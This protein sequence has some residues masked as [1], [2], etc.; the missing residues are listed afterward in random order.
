MAVG[1]FHLSV[2][3]VLIQ[4][5]NKEK[6]NNRKNQVTQIQKVRLESRLTAVFPVMLYQGYASCRVVPF[7]SNRCSHSVR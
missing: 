7:I 4:K 1:L 5:F 3:G 2:T 6:L